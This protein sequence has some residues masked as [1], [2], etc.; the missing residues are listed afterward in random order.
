MLL[1]Y[2]SVHSLIYALTDL[3]REEGS[4]S[5]TLLLPILYYPEEEV[6]NNG[7]FTTVY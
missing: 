3:F 7:D 1:K 4:L 6:R 5:Q 2:L